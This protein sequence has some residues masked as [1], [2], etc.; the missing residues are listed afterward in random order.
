MAS[1]SDE[2]L[3]E[4]ATYLNDLGSKLTLF[5][6]YNRSIELDPDL[7]EAFF[8]L[9]VDLVIDSVA[10]IK[11][12]R[13]NDVSTAVTVMTWTSVHNKFTKTVKDIASKI[14]HL[15]RLV[16]AQNMIEMN[17]TQARLAQLLSELNTRPSSMVERTA[18]IPCMTLPFQR[19]HAFF[20]RSDLLLEVR[21]NLS[22]SP[23]EPSI[24]SLALWGTGGIGKSQIALEYAH[25]EMQIGTQVILWIASETDEEISKSFA[26]AANKLRPEGFSTQNT[27][28]QNRYIVLKWFQTTGKTP[29]GYYTT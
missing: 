14:D 4:I 20:G 24:R 8:D 5:E 21:R 26:D 11:H 16:E 27:P 19:N 10:A 9:L 22:P 28:D 29:S 2:A 25:Q 3:N 12:F 6:M 15:Q 7:L 17:Q 1:E 13:K 23:T 18:N